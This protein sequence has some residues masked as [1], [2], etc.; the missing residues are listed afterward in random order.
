[1]PARP[2]NRSRKAPRR[3][4][5]SQPGRALKSPAVLICLLLVTFFAVWYVLWN[6]VGA[7]QGAGADVLASSEYWVTAAKVRITPPPEWVRRDLRGE[8]FRDAALDEPLSLLDARLVDRIAV[9]F[10][11]HPWVEEVR[12]VIKRYPACVEVELVYRRPVC[13]VE[14]ATGRLLPVDAHGVLLPEEDFSPVEATRYPRLTRVGSEPVGPP[15]SVWGDVRVA[16]GA[17]IAAVLHASWLELGLDRIVPAE[18][19]PG[20]GLEELVFEI[21]TRGGTRILWGHTAGVAI[22]G[23][24]SAEE[25]LA[26]LK[27][28]HADHGTLDGPGGPQILDLEH[29]RVPAAALRPVGGDP[30]ATR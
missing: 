6:G 25:K 23:E 15:G 8:V 29:L 18:S 21:F 20:A 26:L 12:R 10:S 22:P 11:R 5:P 24:L 1:M 17:A 9:A 3:A 16:G 14:L 19:S 2:S 4:A 13:M 28:Y 7:W 27:S 30:V